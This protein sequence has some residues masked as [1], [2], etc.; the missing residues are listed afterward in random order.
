MLINR[1]EAA[2][3]EAERAG[4][5]RFLPTR[6]VRL[7]SAATTSTRAPNTSATAAT[8]FNSGFTSAV[9]KRRILDGSFPIA[10]ASSAFDIPASS[11][12]S[13]S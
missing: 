1:D 7:D 3:R 4:G 13:S 9:K 6:F 5:A 2:G 10:R 12:S 11:R 8:V